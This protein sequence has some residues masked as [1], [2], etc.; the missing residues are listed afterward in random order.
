MKKNRILIALSLIFIWSSTSLFS[1]LKEEI[2]T[3]TIKKSTKELP[4][5]PERTISFT[6]DIGTWLSLDVSPDGQI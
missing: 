4:L 1:Q 2:K 3:D 5:E 6:T